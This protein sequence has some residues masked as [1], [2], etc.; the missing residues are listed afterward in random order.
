[1]SQKAGVKTETATGAQVCR[2]VLMVIQTTRTSLD[3]YLQVM[4]EI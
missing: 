1:M 3:L 2:K 4:E